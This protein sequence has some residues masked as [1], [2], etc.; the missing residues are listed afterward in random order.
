MTF[1][2]RRVLG[3]CPAAEAAVAA[4]RAVPLVTGFAEAAVTVNTSGADADDEG[5]SAGVVPAAGL[6]APVVAAVD[7]V[8][9][10]AVAE[11]AAAAA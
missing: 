11:A 2:G 1:K 4:G 9:A 7:G 10:G 5:V 8:G 3:G 6:A